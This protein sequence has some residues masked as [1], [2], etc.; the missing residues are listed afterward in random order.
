MGRLENRGADAFLTRRAL[1]EGPLQ[2]TVPQFAV[3]AFAKLK[4][5]QVRM[6]EGSKSPPSQGPACWHI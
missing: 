1:S 3:Q 4:V 6:W 5:R 2:V